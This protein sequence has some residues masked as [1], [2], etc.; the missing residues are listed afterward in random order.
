MALSE[1]LNSAILLPD[2]FLGKLSFIFIDYAFLSIS[3]PLSLAV[4]G[5]PANLT[6]SVDHY[7]RTYVDITVS[8]DPPADNFTS[9]YII[10]YQAEGRK[11][12]NTTVHGGERDR[13]LQNGLERGVPYKIFLVALSEHLNSTVGP[14]RF[15][16]MNFSP[17]NLTVLVF[18]HFIY[19][20]IVGSRG[21]I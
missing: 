20:S 3:L 7:S 11:D 15:F 6:T 5:E 2:L 12:I 18:Y 4:P 16:G 14:H 8:W 17:A 10:S 9:E 13:K 1:H 19:S 21:F